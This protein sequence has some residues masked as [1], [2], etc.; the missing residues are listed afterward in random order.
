MD[1]LDK[2]MMI[3]GEE[4]CTHRDARPL[5]APGSQWCP[6]C[7]ALRTTHGDWKAPRHPA[8]QRV[9]APRGV[10]ADTA[11]LWRA[12]QRNLFG[13]CE[14]DGRR[15]LA[16]PFLRFQCD[17]CKTEHQL[18]GLAVAGFR[19][20]TCSACGAIWRRATGGG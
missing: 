15:T 18:R 3:S 13:D 14:D 10:D 2:I 6:D 7:G 16:V 11:V 12:L 4:A 19:S 20:I 8:P 9:R 1:A 5:A 17:E